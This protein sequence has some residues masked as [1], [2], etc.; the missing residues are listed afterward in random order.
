MQLAL[1][2][3]FLRP[4]KPLKRIDGMLL[5]RAAVN[6]A[7]SLSCGET[8]LYCQGQ[9][10]ID[11]VALARSHPEAKLALLGSGAVRLFRR[12]R[13]AGVCCRSWD[14]ARAHRSEEKSRSTYKNAAL[15]RDLLRPP[16]RGDLG[17][18]YIGL[19]H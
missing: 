19:P 7:A 5:L 11:G 15:A 2:E 8:V 10:A 16:P 18:C 13:D 1:E 14:R 6:Q 17:I 3:R 12:T 9:R 4:A